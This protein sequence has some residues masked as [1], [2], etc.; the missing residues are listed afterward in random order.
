MLLRYPWNMPARSSAASGALLG[1]LRCPHSPHKP[2]SHHR[3][4][5]KGLNH[6]R[7]PGLVENLAYLV[8]SRVEYLSKLERVVCPPDEGSGNAQRLYGE[9]QQLLRKVIQRKLVANKRQ[10]ATKGLRFN[11]KFDHILKLKETQSIRC[12]ACNTVLLW[13]YQ[14]KNTQQFSES[15]FH[16]YHA[17]IA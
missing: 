6:R 4:P 7:L 8:V 15:A 5:T 3:R 10:D 12:A 11:L 9:P 1:S 16:Y 17:H 14:S 13:A 2:R